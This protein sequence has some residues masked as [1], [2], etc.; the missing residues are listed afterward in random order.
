[1]RLRLQRQRMSLL[2]AMVAIALVAGTGTIVTGANRHPGD[3]HH[4]A[5]EQRRPT[6]RA[7]DRRRGRELQHLPLLPP[8]RV[9]RRIS[10]HR[11]PRDLQLIR[12]RPTEELR[13]GP[14]AGRGDASDESQALPVSRR[15]E[16]PL[17]FR[18]VLRPDGVA[19]RRC[20]GA[21]RVSAAQRAR[22]RA[23]RQPEVGVEG[24]ASR[25][26]AA[27]ARGHLFGQGPRDRL[28]GHRACSRCRRALSRRATGD[29]R[30]L[31]GDRAEPLHVLRDQ[32]HLEPCELVV[33]A[34]GQ[35][36]ERRR[37]DLH[38]RRGVG[39]AFIRRFPRR[40][41]E[42]RAAVELDHLRQLHPRHVSDT[43]HEPRPPHLREHRRQFGSRSN[44]ARPAVQRSERRRGEDRRGAGK[45][46]A[47]RTSR[48]HGAPSTTRP[49]A[50][51]W[52]IRR[53]TP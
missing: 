8:A 42:A 5:S 13:G 41:N 20:S 43:R 17:G 16:E 28:A 32:R 29:Q 52:A 7:A 6:R 51:W 39:S 45:V 22:H 37:L 47:R 2:C 3:R 53:T 14:V 10:D 19:P 18:R 23:A 46:W 40:G 48:S 30:P 33:R 24:L 31:L 44:R 9:R 1:M 50:C 21:R 11:L 38:A 49:R 36:H 25:R 34:P 27:P 15:G 4:R 12:R 35:A 26:R